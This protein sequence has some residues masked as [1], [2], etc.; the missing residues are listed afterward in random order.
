MVTMAVPERGS[1]P[2]GMVK[3]DVRQGRMGLTFTPDEAQRHAALEA[4]EGPLRMEATPL[5]MAVLNALEGIPTYYPMVVVRKA[6][7]MPDHLHLILEVTAPIVSSNG[8]PRHLGHVLAG[9]KKGCNRAYWDICSM[10]EPWNTEAESAP[11]WC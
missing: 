1:N 8:T 5:G 9:Y 6:Q 4:G 11:L 7:L 3:G 2:F 10:G